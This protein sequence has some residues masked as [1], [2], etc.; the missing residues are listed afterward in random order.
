MNFTESQL[1]QK[2]SIIL[3]DPPWAYNDR[4]LI[5]KDGKRPRA[6]M[7]AVNHYPLMPFEDICSLP[8]SK[9]T[10]DNAALFLWMTPPYSNKVEE[11]IPFYT[12]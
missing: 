11:V 2:Y 8:V 1:N 3:A 9:I 5:R 10:N 12:F 6:G 4:K 7:G